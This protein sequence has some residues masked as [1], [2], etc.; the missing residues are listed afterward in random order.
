LEIGT[1][2]AEEQYKEIKHKYPVELIQ[3][4]SLKHLSSVLGIAP[5]SLSRIRKKPH[6]N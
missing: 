4:I 5:Q 1:V 3:K 6:T 2:T